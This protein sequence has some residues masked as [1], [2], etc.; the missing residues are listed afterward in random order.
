TYFFRM[1][2]NSV[3][4]R[5]RCCTALVLDWLT[6][7]LIASVPDGAAD[8]IERHSRPAQKHDM[9]SMPSPYDRAWLN[10][11]FTMNHSPLISNISIWSGIAFCITQSAIFSGLNLAIFSISKLPN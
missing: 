3:D 9:R 5:Y 10:G 2:W 6:R 7:A 8:L 11:Y 4:G 1:G